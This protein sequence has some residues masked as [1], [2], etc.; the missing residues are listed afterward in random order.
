MSHHL[1]PTLST[2]PTPASTPTLPAA[3]T[4]LV[5]ICLSLGMMMTQP[6]LADE[7]ALKEKKE[8]RLRV[9]TAVAMNYCSAAFYRI[10]KYPTPQVLKEERDKILNNLNLNEIDDEEVIRLYSGVLSEINGNELSKRERSILTDKHS[11][12]QNEKIWSRVVEASANLATGN[13]V[14]LVNTGAGSWWDYRTLDWQRDLELWRIERSQMSGIYD[15]SSQFLNTFWKLGRKRQIP[16]NWLIREG[17]LDR[18]EFAMQQPKLDARLRILKRLKDKMAYYPPC[19]YYLARTQQQMGQLYDATQT[20]KQLQELSEGHFRSD[21]MLAAGLA[22]MA[23]IQEHLKDPN[24]VRTARSALQQSSEAWQVNLVCSRILSRH[25]KYEEAE[26]SVLRNLDV[27]LEKPQSTMGLLALYYHSN[28]KSKMLS[29]LKDPE[30]LALSPPPFLLQCASILDSQEIPGRLKYHLAQSIQARPELNYYG[31]DD[32]VITVNNQWQLER[33]KVMVAVGEQ[34]LRSPSVQNV[35][36]NLVV[37]YKQAMEWGSPMR[38]NV[39]VSP[40]TMVLQYPDMPRLT[41]KMAPAQTQ[42]QETIANKRFQLVVP[43][44]QLANRSGVTLQLASVGVDRK[45][46]SFQSPQN[47]LSDNSDAPTLTDK[48]EV[49]SANQTHQ[50]AKPVSQSKAIDSE[51]SPFDE[52]YIEPDQYPFSAGPKQEIKSDQPATLRGLIKLEPSN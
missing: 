35:N 21:E 10:K 40:V 26:D 23:I 46:I 42:P 37:R 13:V 33:A 9:S 4:R 28:Q 45:L 16:D 44:N 27:N 6:V 1:K 52:D 8:L 31:P 43:K 25:Q 2:M 14:G 39:Q 3:L 7:A 19:L 34:R 48:D 38:G 41:L 50:S 36:Q 20:Y 24:S 47:R 17:E 18:L 12:I 51:A 15:K 11:Q 30:V 32:L 5:L 49:K 22:N 29:R